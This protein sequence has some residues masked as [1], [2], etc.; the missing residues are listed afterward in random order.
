MQKTKAENGTEQPQ[1]TATGM[2]FSQSFEMGYEDKIE[3]SR[4]KAKERKE[5]KEAAKAGTS[6]AETNLPGFSKEP[7][8]GDMIKRY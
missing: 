4:K 2:M 8:D 3:E 7:N 6:T 5:A 1:F